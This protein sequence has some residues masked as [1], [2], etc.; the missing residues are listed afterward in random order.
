[1]TEEMNFYISAAAATSK[2]RN[3]IKGIQVNTNICG[4]MIEECREMS[5]KKTLISASCNLLVS[6]FFTSSHVFQKGVLSSFWEYDFFTCRTTWLQQS[7]ILYVFFPTAIRQ[8]KAAML[9][10]YV[11]R[12]NAQN[13]EI[14][15]SKNANGLRCRQAALL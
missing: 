8:H 12:Q 5:W 10:I 4:F 6:L 9:F 2:S 7:L 11:V 1:M 15:N 13:L 14:Y 3:S